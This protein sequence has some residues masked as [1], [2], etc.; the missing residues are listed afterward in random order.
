M[1]R[2]QF[3]A[4]AFAAGA[5]LPSWAAAEDGRPY[6]VGLI[7]CGWY[8]NVDLHRLLD[9]SKAEVASLCD[10]DEKHLNDSAEE[11]V[12]R[13][14][15]K[16]KLYRDYRKMLD[17]EKHDIVLVGTPDHWHALQAIAAMEHGADVYCQKPISVD[18]MEG[19]A[20]VDAAARTQRV[21]QIGTQR[22]STRHLAEARDFL[23]GG[24]LGKL[25]MVRGFCYYNM[26]GNENPPDTAPPATL[27]YENWVGPAPML[28]FN[29]LM[30]PRGWRRFNEFGNGIMGDMG[31]HMLDTMRWMLG[32]GWPKSVS[33]TGG[34]FVY[35]GKSN[36]PDTQTASFDFGDFVA[37]WEHRTYGRGEEPKWS[38]GLAF[39]GEKGELR[40]SLDEW[41][42]L[43]HWNGGKA[44][45]GKGD[46]VPTKGWKITEED[47]VVIANRAHQ[48]NFLECVKSRG[49]PIATIEEGHTST[50]MCILANLALKL[51]RTLAW[52]PVKHEVVGDAEATAMLKRPYR[53]PWQHPA[54]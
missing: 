4:S 18:V 13:G 19:K 25:G 22:R 47:N 2:R 35:P 27:D 5:A 45:G 40:V 11:V 15:A 10:V 17:A 34:T 41:E 7:G 49:K 16:P 42:F 43:P 29:K 33:S 8:G 30:H 37:V 39:Y 46:R 44:A 26:R 38:W 36:I 48:T 14:L 3:A 51:K 1:N 28:P 31:V 52:D 32:V 21:V 9:V 50:A 54:G 53:A 23:R 24:A 12:K 6:R 20:M